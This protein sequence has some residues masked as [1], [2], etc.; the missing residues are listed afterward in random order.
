MEKKKKKDTF[1]I[2]GLLYFFL[3]NIKK[4]LEYKKIPPKKKELT[5][6]NKKIKI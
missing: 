1:Y 2:Q 3:M 4:I 5:I 6:K